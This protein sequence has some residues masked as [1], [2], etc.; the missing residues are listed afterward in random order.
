M[1]RKILILGGTGEGAAL[2][3]ALNENVGWLVIS[4]LA[5][6]VANP[7]L[8]P[9]EIRIGGFGGPE[10]L[11]DYLR[12]ENIAAMIDATHPFARRMGWNAATAAQ[13]IGVPLLR[14]ERPAWKAQA[15]DRWTEVES[16]DEAV[17]L[18]RGKQRRVFLAL[19]RQ[20]LAPFAALTDTH[21]VIRSVEAPDTGIKF[22]DAELVLAR[23]P[24]KLEGERALLRQHR[25]DCIVCKNSGGSATDG[26]LIAAREL[27]IEVMMQRRPKRPD[28]TAV[29]NVAK[30]T[31]WLSA[32]APA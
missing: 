5:G 8:P 21:F 1:R 25:I 3:E 9:G 17:A 4:S 6:R 27:G 14:L 15:G 19:G 28:V 22:A 32:L 7:R 23:G 12:R 10:G 26:K 29:D 30:A 24:F 16:W 31:D 20:E 13:A 2:A 11:A 18:L